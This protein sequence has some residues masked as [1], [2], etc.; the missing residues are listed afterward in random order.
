MLLEL[1]DIV[2]KDLMVI[3]GIKEMYRLR[4]ISKHVKWRLE[5]T[6]KY[7]YNRLSKKC[8]ISNTNNPNFNSNSIMNDFLP[9]ITFP[10]AYQNKV[11]YI[12]LKQIYQLKE[13]YYL[14]ED[15]EK[16]NLFNRYNLTMLKKLPSYKIRA[17]KILLSLGVNSLFSCKIAALDVQQIKIGIKLAKIGIRSLFCL[18][19]AEEFNSEKTDT[20]HYLASLTN[21]H[22]FAF[23]AAK[24]LNQEEIQKMVSNMED[25]ENIAIAYHRIRKHSDESTSLAMYL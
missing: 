24:M 11:N 15:L 6:I 3:L 23:M 17:A 25:G 13:W 18:R 21:N 14:I 2:W 12:Y 20:L 22:Y 1:P 5:C 4:V 8:F 10:P 16:N 19:A 9:T 7:T